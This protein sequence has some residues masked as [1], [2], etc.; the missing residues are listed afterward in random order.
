VDEVADIRKCEQEQS[1]NFV[2]GSPDR[3]HLRVSDGWPPRGGCSR[4]HYDA[5]DS[6][7]VQAMKFLK[8]S[9]DNPRLKRA[10]TE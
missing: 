8:K 2:G 10:A 6:N 3:Q 1:G 9:M 4:D 7:T 5:V